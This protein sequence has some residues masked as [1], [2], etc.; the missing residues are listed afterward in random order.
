MKLNAGKSFLKTFA[1]SL[2]FATFR[3]IIADWPYLLI[4]LVLCNM[5]FTTSEVVP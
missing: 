1:I 2:E 5:V 3:L 4:K